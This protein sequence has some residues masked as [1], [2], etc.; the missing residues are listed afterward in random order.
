MYAVLTNPAG[1]VTE[2]GPF[3]GSCGRPCSLPRDDRPASAITAVKVIRRSSFQHVT[4][5]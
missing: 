4:E 1:E 3:T 5:S 2:H